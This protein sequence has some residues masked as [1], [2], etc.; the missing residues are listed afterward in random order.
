MIGII[1]ISL[2][3]NKY[4]LSIPFYHY[5]LTKKSVY[6]PT[7][8]LPQISYLNFST[9]T[10]SVGILHIP[11]NIPI[12]FLTT[13]LV[14]ALSLGTSLSKSTLNYHSGGRSHRTHCTSHA[15]SK[16]PCKSEITTNLQ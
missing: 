2:K 9:S 7:N 13:K 15:L 16:R 4:T 11:I 3:Q 1:I 14:H 8:S 10:K 12:S 6:R 5:M